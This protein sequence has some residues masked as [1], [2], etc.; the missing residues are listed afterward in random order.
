MKFVSCLVID[1]SVSIERREGEWQTSKYLHESVLYFDLNL[2]LFSCR[3][4][5]RLEL[6]VEFSNSERHIVE[7]HWNF[8]CTKYMITMGSLQNKIDPLCIGNCE[9]NF[10]FVGF[11]I[12][13][14]GL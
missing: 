4:L 2:T 13:S 7:P 5:K 10:C 12:S 8:P 14:M 6:V 11:F 3:A 9:S 1:H